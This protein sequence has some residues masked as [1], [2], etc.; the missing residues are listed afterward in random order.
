MASKH[1]NGDV[2]VSCVL[3]LRIPALVDWLVV[4]LSVVDVI[5]CCALSQINYAWPSAEIAVM[6]ASGAV[7]ILFHGA[8]DEEI[9]QRTTESVHCFFV[10]Q[11]NTLDNVN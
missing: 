5:M 6:G 2:S 3:S 7:K 10:L 1:L 11:K 8:D 4:F 9:Q